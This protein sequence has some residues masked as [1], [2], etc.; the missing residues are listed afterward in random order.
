MLG[1]KSAPG[2]QV[3]GREIEPELEGSSAVSHGRAWLKHANC[4]VCRQPVVCPMNEV[5]IGSGRLSWAMTAKH[6]T[7]ADMLHKGARILTGFP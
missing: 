3:V 4:H 5:E 1:S 7:A 2:R 6:G